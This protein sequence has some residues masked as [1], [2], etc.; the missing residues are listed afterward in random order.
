M[1]ITDLKRTST[2]LTLRLSLFNDADKD[3]STS[4]VFTEPPYRGYR[5][6]AGIH[7][8]DAASK[9]KY[10]V[11][12]DSENKCLCS[13]DIP[14]IPKKSQI[15]VWAKFPAPADDVQK[16]TVQVPHFVP[17]EDVPISR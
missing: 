9:K 6:V 3:F 7:L 15:N 5:T 4:S 8:I 16:M 13:D 2:T 14:D 17:I 10:F 11:V 12:A 1:T